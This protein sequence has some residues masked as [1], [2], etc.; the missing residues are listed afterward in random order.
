[1]Y[2]HVFAWEL[3][4]GPIP[5]GLEVCHSCDVPDCCEVAHMRLGTRRHNVADRTARF[6]TSDGG[7]GHGMAKLTHAEAA[8][9]RDRARAGEPQSLLAAEYGISRS[10]VSSIKVGRSRTPS[11]T[12]PER[13]P[14]P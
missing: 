12:V 13:W 9:V 7:E 4:H 11:G 14:S 8:D 6:A 1:M 3:A 2:A 5:D 10:H